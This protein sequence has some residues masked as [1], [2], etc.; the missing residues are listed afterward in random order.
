MR[1]G[2]T[3]SGLR[4][5]HIEQ[6]RVCAVQ[7]HSIALVCQRDGYLQGQVDRLSRSTFRVSTWQLQQQHLL[8]HI[9][10]KALASVYAFS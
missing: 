7:A 1:P 4:T 9:T 8:M 5:V 3:S 10:T 2:T 6:H